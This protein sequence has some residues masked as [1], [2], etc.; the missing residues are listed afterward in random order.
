MIKAIIFDCFNVL[1]IDAHKSLIEQYPSVATELLD[2]R[3]Q[4]D[5]GMLD[6]NQYIQAISDVTKLDA[7][8]IEKT[9]QYEHTLNKPLVNFIK[10]ELKPHY[11]IGMLSNI[12]RG[13]MQD[14]FSEHDLHQLFDAVVLSGEERVVKPNPK[15]Y[16]IIAGKTGVLTEEC[17]MID[18]IPA[19][20]EGARQAGMQAVHYQSVEQTKQQLKHLLALQ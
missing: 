7:A 4:A 17:V 15:I 14:F 10:I 9:I 11:K 20:C 3:R 19:N 16:E 2:L 12:G 6:K 5:L 13:W 8:K 1:Y 18:D